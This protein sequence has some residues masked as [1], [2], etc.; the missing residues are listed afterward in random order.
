MSA[1][2]YSKIMKMIWHDD[3]QR[4]LMLQ[5]IKDRYTEDPVEG[6]SKRGVKVVTM[7]LGGWQWLGVNGSGV[8]VD[9]CYGC[10]KVSGNK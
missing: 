1:S 8:G 4:Q 9:R 2:G 10:G 7:G 3:L 5:K 6:G